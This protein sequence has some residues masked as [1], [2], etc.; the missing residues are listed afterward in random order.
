MASGFGGT[1]PVLSRPGV[2]WTVDPSRSTEHV[3]GAIPD[4]TPEVSLQP[5]RHN[6]TDT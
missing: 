1:P 5:R 6:D 2:G 3:P 4:Y